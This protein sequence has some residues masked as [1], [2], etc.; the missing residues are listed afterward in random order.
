MATSEEIIK[1]IIGKALLVKVGQRS[2]FIIKKRVADGIFLKGSSPGADKYST[3][4]FAMPIGAVKKKKVLLDILKGKHLDDTQIFTSKKSGK[5]WVVIKK[6]YKWLREQSGKNAGRVD[7]T[8][9]REMMR[10]LQVLKINNI[11]LY[12][13]SATCI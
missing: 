12:N 7:L 6:G 4:P 11:S 2:V 10:S 3:K 9:T 13:F 1:E 8:W 5:L